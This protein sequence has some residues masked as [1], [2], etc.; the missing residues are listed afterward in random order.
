MN[1]AI[2]YGSLAYLPRLGIGN[3]KL[4]ITA[5]FVSFIYKLLVKL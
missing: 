3:I 1:Q 2:P 4:L 5:M